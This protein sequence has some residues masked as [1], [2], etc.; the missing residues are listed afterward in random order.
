MILDRKEIK[1]Y[2]TD[3]LLELIDTNLRYLRNHKRFI[4]DKYYPSLEFRSNDNSRFNIGDSEKER[5]NTK[6]RNQFLH[7]YKKVEY[8]T[9]IMMKEVNSRL[10]IPENTE[11]YSVI[12]EGE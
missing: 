9:A 11:L 1:D 8:Y 10:M 12:N 6:L 5:H 3:R 4:T 7:I 2:K